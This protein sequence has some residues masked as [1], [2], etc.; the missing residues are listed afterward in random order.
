MMN[1]DKSF[2]DHIGT[3]ISDANVLP[4]AISTRH[5]VENIQLSE[6][7]P[8]LFLFELNSDKKSYILS[9]KNV[10]LLPDILSLPNQYNNLPV[11]NI[12]YDGFHASSTVKTLFIPASIKSI[13]TPPFESNIGSF[14]SCTNLATIVFENKSNLTTIGAYGFSG[15]TSLKSV[16]IPEK[17]Q[18][19]DYASFSYCSNLESVT[20]SAMH[21]PTLGKFA[22]YGTSQNFKIYV[23][24]TMLKAYKSNPNWYE[25][26]DK[27]FA[28]DTT[29]PM[30]G[31]DQ[32][33]TNSGTIVSVVTVV[34]NVV[35]ITIGD[36][37][38]DNVTINTK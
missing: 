26:S 20:I 6:T 13:D 25:Y 5:F 19:I 10:T 34:T 11:T 29:P 21:V 33:V 3:A 14:S 17:I 27:I 1:I 32:G 7:D 30:Y 8:S 2:L 31:F 4:S 22:F 18:L 36:V 23:P 9:A 38:I 16:I 15:C 24:S 35:N 12:K 28:S 37:R